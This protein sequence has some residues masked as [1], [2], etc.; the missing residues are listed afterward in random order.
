MYVKRWTDK[1]SLRLL[2]FIPSAILLIYLVAVLTAD[3]MK[4]AHQPM[5]G[6]F[7]ILFFLITVPKMLFTLFDA[8]GLAGRRLCN[9][10]EASAKNSIRDV[11]DYGNDERNAHDGNKVEDNDDIKSD[12]NSRGN[13]VHRYIRLLAMALAMM[14]VFIILYG[15]IWGRSNYKVYTH[16]VYFKNLPEAFDGYRILQFSD[17][18]VG[19]FDD[20]H[21]DDV[22]T[23]VSLI[24]SQKCD[25]VVFTGDIVNYESAELEGYEQILSKIKA[26]DGVFSIMGNH[27]YDMYL[28]FDSEKVKNDDIEKIKRLERSYGWNLL[29]NEN[30]II[31]RGNDSIAIAGTE[32][33]GLPPWPELGDL[34]KASEGLEG[35]MRNSSGTAEKNAAEDHTFSILLTHDPTFWR[36]SI[37]PDSRFDLT[38][39]G[40]THAGQFKILG[41]SPIQ[42][43]YDEW[44]GF[45]EEGQ[46]LLNVNDGIGQILLPFRFGVWPALDVI[47]LRKEK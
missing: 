31:R 34:N 12:D 24:N 28:K 14:S 9:R 6:T 15:Y 40:H 19:T 26:P 44:S 42:F 33:D 8:I 37:L 46:Q 38:L 47:T 27:D 25:A 4:T 35:M 41:W 30:K 43:K 3:D 45:Y 36:R 1:W 16:E 10:L 29:L 20:G 11:L 32:N 5:I 21:R 17:L 22:S 13:K 18:H 23:I 39:A 7:V 2:S